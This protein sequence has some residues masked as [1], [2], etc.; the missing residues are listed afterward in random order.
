MF[1]VIIIGGGVVGASVAHS[2]AKYQLSACLVESE[3]DVCMG[4][5][6]A[7]SGVVHAGFDA[8]IG[9]NKAKF[10]VL[11]NKM[12]EKLCKDLG[13]KYKNNGSLVVAFSNEELA[14]LQE[15]LERGKANGVDGLEIIDEK[16]LRELEPNVSKNALGALWAKTAGIVCPYQ[17]TIALIGNAM[18]NG[19]EL[20]TDFC[21]SSA[22]KND[23]YYTL[24]S[25]NGDKIDGKIIV[26]CAGI[27]AGKVAELFGDNSIQIGARR[28]QYVLIDK[29]P[30]PFVTRTMFFT[31]TK[32]GK[33]ILVVPTVDGNIM[34]GPTAEELTEFN[35]ETTPEGLDFVL[36]KA[37]TMCDNVPTYDTITSF[38]GIRS[39]SYTHDFIIENSAVDKNL[40][41]CV[42]IESPGLTSAPS[43]G[44]YVVNGLIGQLLPLVNKENYNPY[45]K[46]EYFFNNLS[47]EEKNNI[48]S[49]NPS[50]AKIV[51]RCEK[52]TEGEIIAACTQNPKTTTVDGVKRRTRAGMGRCQG[53][54]C[55]PYVMEIISKCNNIDYQ[56]VTKSGKNSVILQGVTK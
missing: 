15:L 26:N 46:A 7:N 48:V 25:T 53:G 29:Q 47:V 28:G 10:N 32:L 36:K 38:S 23:G 3:A 5:S 34:L 13:V 45:R 41:N 9:S 19:V 27:N 6:R 17:L 56:N 2:L 21:V 42:G 31:P 43:I 4:A 18:D 30:T 22:I 11:G 20:V 37:S 52:I 49:K 16:K 12:M 33:G 8:P 50:Y 1:D 40:I 55:Q 51:C 35:V 24:V 39:Y 54:F 44:E 14:T